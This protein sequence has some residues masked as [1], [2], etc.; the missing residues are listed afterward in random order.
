MT[1]A[2]S[3]PIK[4]S[5]VISDVDGALVTNEKVPTERT[6]TA[7]AALRANGIIFSIISSRPPRGLGMLIHPS[8]S[9]RRLSAST[10]GC[11]RPQTSQSFP[12]IFCRQ[13]SPAAWSTCSTHAESMFGSSAVR[14]GWCATRMPPR[15]SVGVSADFEHL[16]R[17]EGE[18]RGA[19]GEQASADFVTGSNSKTVSLKLSSNSF[20]RAVAPLDRI[21]DRSSFQSVLSPQ[22]RERLPVPCA[23]MRADSLPLATRQASR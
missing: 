23:R 13:A 7:A 3:R 8:A 17:C 21:G 5:A 15:R 1:R 10:A 16:A 20:L 9:P 4:C 18:L 14:T 6:E 11:W 22:P 12:H 19:L 2:R